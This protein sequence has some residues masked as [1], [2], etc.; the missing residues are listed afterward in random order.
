MLATPITVLNVSG[1]PSRRGGVT[2]PGEVRKG[3]HAIVRPGVSVTLIGEVAAGSRYVKGEDGRY[4]TT[5]AAPIVYR[6]HFVLGGQAVY[7]GYN[8]TYTGKII[9]IGEKTVT[10]EAYSGTT[11][12]RKHRLDLADFSRQNWDYDAAAISKRNSE[13]MD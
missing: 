1:K 10:V 9:A 2:R 8:L 13:W 12:A 6:K 11:S 5:N 4:T 7:G 3:H